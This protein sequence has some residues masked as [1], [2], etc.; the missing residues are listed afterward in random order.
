MIK[1]NIFL[2]RI[3]YI[4]LVFALVFSLVSFSAYAEDDYIVIPDDVTVGS[5]GTQFA[6]G[7]IRENV[8]IISGRLSLDQ[9]D[10]VIPGLGALGISLNRIYNNN[11]WSVWRQPE[12]RFH[13][14]YNLRGGNPCPSPDSNPWGWESESFRDWET[15]MQESIEQRGLETSEEVKD[16]WQN[17]WNDIYNREQDAR[18]TGEQYFAHGTPDYD[19]LCID[20]PGGRDASEGGGNLYLEYI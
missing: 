8:D 17:Y 9:T 19:E 5:A 11:L 4:C 1:L 12:E 16:Y 7:N 13:W 14:G 20:G 15:E 2:S 3:I 6:S 10:A 18:G